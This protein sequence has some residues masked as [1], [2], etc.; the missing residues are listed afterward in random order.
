M[1]CRLVHNNAQ[2]HFMVRRIP[3]Q[4]LDRTCR[5]ERFV[6]CIVDDL[7]WKLASCRAS[8]PALPSRRPIVHTQSRQA[9]LSVYAFASS[10][11][12][13]Y[14][15]VPAICSALSITAD[16]VHGGGWSVEV[17]LARQEG[18]FTWGVGGAVEIGAWWMEDGR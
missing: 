12:G 11:R 14:S 16:G 6:W 18:A 7:Y 9:C 8:G 2:Q 1:R 13:G 5:H 10:H 3:Y 15:I 4:I 17:R